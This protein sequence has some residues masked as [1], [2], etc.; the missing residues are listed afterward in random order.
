MKNKCRS[1]EENKVLI[2]G[3]CEEC[4]KILMGEEKSEEKKE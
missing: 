4:D 3:Y 1:C 2:N